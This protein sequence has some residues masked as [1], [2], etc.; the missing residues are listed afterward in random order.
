MC[1]SV[2][3]P[4]PFGPSSPVTPGPIVIVM[5]LTATTLPYQ[6]DTALELELGHPATA[7]MSRSMR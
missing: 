6:R 5:S 2:D 3:L 4:A 1:S 7:L